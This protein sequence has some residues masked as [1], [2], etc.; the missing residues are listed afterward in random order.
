MCVYQGQLYNPVALDYAKTIR[1]VVS[2][3]PHLEHLDNETWVRIVEMGFNVV[4]GDSLRVRIGGEEG[5]EE[6]SIDMGTEGGDSDLPHDDENDTFATTS[7]QT[8]KRRRQ[9]ASGTPGP[10]FPRPSPSSTKVLRSVSL[11]Q[12]EFASLL[13]ILLRSPSAPLLSSKYPCLANDILT[14]LLRFIRNYSEDTSLHQDFLAALSATLSHLAL[15]KR[16]AVSQFA[17][18]AWDGLIGIW[19]TKNKSMKEGLIVVLRILFPYYTADDPKMKDVSLDGPH[20]DGITKL[21]NL[22]GG[23]VDNRWG[24]QGLSLDSLRLQLTLPDDLEGCGPAAFVART[25]RYGWNFDPAQALA[26]AI[27]ELQADCAAKVHSNLFGH[28]HL[29]INVLGSC[30]FCPN[31]SILRRNTAKGME[32]ESSLTILSHRCWILSELRHLPSFARTTSRDYSLSLI[33]TGP[34]FTTASVRT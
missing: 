6:G 18:G 27:L 21:W 4:L 31:P 19:G 28:S 9:E 3:M 5:D 33:D 29:L 17:L 26:W 32:K 2:Y 14:R 24:F 15:N 11:E 25:F 23:T 34:Y 22:L 8:K 12:I 7:T 20:I 16:S 13:A 10:S 30:S 1:C